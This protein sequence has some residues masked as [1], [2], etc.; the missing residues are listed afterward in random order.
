MSSRPRAL[1][2][3]QHSVGIGHLMRFVRIIDALRHTFD[4]T[5]VSG[6]HW[7]ASLTLPA[8]VDCVQLPPLR[9]HDY[10]LHSDGE[11]LSAVR[12]A[13]RRQLLALVRGLRPAVFLIELYPF[14]RKK[15]AF[16]LLPA[17]IAARR[18]APAP[19][20]LCSLRDI[21]VDTRPDQ[22]RHDARA[23]RLMNRYFDGA[24]V[25]ADPAFMRLEDSFRPR[26]ALRVPVWYTGFVA[27]SPP[28]DLP[29]S[30]RDNTLVVSAGGGRVGAELLSATLAAYHAWQGPRPRLKLIAGP[31]ADPTVRDALSAAAR[32]QG[33]I[34][35]LSAVPNL[36]L[37]LSRARYSVS[38]AGYNTVMDVLVSGVRGLLVPY[39]EGRE[40]EQLRRA[41]RLAALGLARHVASEDAL[42]PAF[43]STLRSLATFEPKSHGY[44]LDG[45]AR[46]K[47]LIAEL[48]AG[49]RTRAVA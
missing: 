10:A 17:L 49:R 42:T 20:V 38:Q 7:P 3:C 31:L 19:V 35:V 14:G 41:Q 9:T 2:Y 40:N 11:A 45:A 1:L 29:F 16:E 23:A 44:A 24:L 6:G 39:A 37:E 22:P 36:A 47:A 27:P 5:L 18:C 25:H 15:F 21:L 43:G 32:Q 30:A 28:V 4:I 33:D 34:E 12:L 48:V 8:E 46:T 26:E 13:R